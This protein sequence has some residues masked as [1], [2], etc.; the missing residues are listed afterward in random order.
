MVIGCWEALLTLCADAAEE[1]AL[2]ANR[3]ARRLAG[4]TA[5]LCDPR[6]E[7]G[8]EGA[9]AAAEGA[10]R[11]LVLSEPVAQRRAPQR[12]MIAQAL[13]ALVDA[14][15]A[16]DPS[17]GTPTPT[18]TPTP[19]GVLSA[20]HLPSVVGALL[21][22]QGALEP[23]ALELLQSV[24]TV[25]DRARSL[26]LE[27]SRARSA[28]A[29]PI[30]AALAELLPLAEPRSRPMLLA[31]C[32]DGLR[33]AAPLATKSA[34]AMAAAVLLDVMAADRAGGA[35]RGGA[36]GG[37]PDGEAAPAS[38]REASASDRQVPASD[39]E[40]VPASDR[41]AVPASDREAA[42]STTRE[43]APTTTRAP[44]PTTTRAPTP[45]THGVPAAS[46]PR[47]AGADASRAALRVCLGACDAALSERSA[48]L[49]RRFTSVVSSAFGVVDSASACRALEALLERYD[50]V[51]A[52]EDEEDAS[53]SQ[54]A[55]AA[56]G[57]ADASEASLSPF[58]LRKLQIARLLRAA[59][60][61][62]RGLSSGG[63]ALRVLRLS[64]FSRR[65]PGR[66]GDCWGAVHADVCAELDL[67]GDA[68]C[69]REAPAT[70]VRACV[71]A[72][73]G[74]SWRA[75]RRAA[76]AAELIAP[77]LPAAG[78]EDLLRPMQWALA[79]RLAQRGAAGDRSAVVEGL[80]RAACAGG[81]A[82]AG[83][84]GGSWDHPLLAA[85]VE[86]RRAWEDA[87]TGARP[88]ERRRLARLRDAADDEDLA[89]FPPAPAGPLL[90]L[91]AA[92][93]AAGAQRPAA[94]RRAAAAAVTALLRARADAAEGLEGVGAALF[95][96][97][98]EEA[99]EPATAGLAAAAMTAAAAA[100]AEAP[101]VLRY[102]GAVMERRPAAA[103]N[104]RLAALRAAERAVARLPPGADGTLAELAPG[105]ASAARAAMLFDAR[106]AKVRQA[107]VK[108]LLAVAG[109][110][111]AN[112]AALPWDEA[113]VGE[114][115][116]AALE[117]GVRETRDLGRRLQD[118]LG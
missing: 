72:V 37:A 10:L 95:A 74:R 8:A 67:E 115:V 68:A 103:W 16:P 15:V 40:A 36:D 17:G 3:S 32:A 80:L 61:R 111:A 42:P 78:R 63:A 110:A 25:E 77:H 112:G 44:T 65:E 64:F 114:V 38:D 90:R 55:G 79:H 105:A 96:V 87:A 75:R 76:E 50:A 106:Q 85:V 35:A 18:P 101:E 14:A 73:L 9:E 118:A 83:G 81:A 100:A 27:E 89:A 58:A 104:V 5:A 86:R 91:F 53:S 11:C 6:G 30:A 24:L 1:V 99:A 41:E 46:T 45:T 43:A 71:A 59:L 98:M 108:L 2:A 4:L 29:S 70:L 93:A 20:A 88:A 113:T 94:E 60:S 92:V 51:R 109:A 48:A 26:A 69:V 62:R 33:G 22:L 19:T 52:D 54:D 47:A 82:A 102:A 7:G 117:D 116:R 28:Q 34:A 107:A 97:A 57:A 49:R 84:W 21:E 39:R 23:D 66:A 31:K 12:A 13:L 56:P